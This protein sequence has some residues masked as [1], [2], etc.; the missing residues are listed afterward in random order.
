[1]NDKYLNEEK[2]LKQMIDF[3]KSKAKKQAKNGIAMIDDEVVYGWAIHYFDETNEALGLNK[4]AITK[5]KVSE[6]REVT[7]EITKSESKKKNW[8]PEGQLSLFDM[9]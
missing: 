3:I 4:K 5:E 7:K 2:S 6:D 1:M 9:V 8:I